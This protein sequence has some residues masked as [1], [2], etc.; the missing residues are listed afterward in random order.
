MK[1]FILF[2]PCCHVPFPVV[3]AFLLAVFVLGLIFFI[4]SEPSQHISRSRNA[5]PGFN[6]TL[7]GLVGVQ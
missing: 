2:C 4:L 1:M 6:S 5:I 3:D 7:V